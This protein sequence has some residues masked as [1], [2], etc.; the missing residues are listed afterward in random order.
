MKAT[1]TRTALNERFNEQNIT[2]AIEIVVH[3]LAVLCK[4]VR[5]MTKF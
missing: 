4:K 3:L 5:E 1:A 2:I